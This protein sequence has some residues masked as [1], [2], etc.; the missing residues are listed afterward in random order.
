MKRIVDMK[1]VYL[2]LGSNIGNGRQY[3]LAA[4]K[5]LR[6][7]AL[8]EIQCSSFWK[9]EPVEMNEA[10]WFTNAVVRFYT[11]LSPVDL[12]QAIQGIEHKSGRP[13]V[14]VQNS[15]RTLDLDI[16]TYENC[17]LETDSLKIPH[18]R[19]RQRLFVLLPLQELAPEFRFP[20]LRINISELIENA[21]KI[22]M[23]RLDHSW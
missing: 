6:R 1:L 9:T 14:H 18:P 10:R 4:L 19:A 15:P 21:P 17:I 23:E 5:M 3:L 12:L 22:K 7:I 8:G 13:V 16:I 20:G 2:A 11:D